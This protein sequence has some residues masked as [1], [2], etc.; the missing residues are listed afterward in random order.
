MKRNDNDV[1]TDEVRLWFMNGEGTM[2][3]RW[4]E[5]MVFE[6]HGLRL[7]YPMHD[8]VHPYQALKRILVGEQ[9]RGEM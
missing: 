4:P 8:E 9:F 7:E 6:E 2:E 3:S 5:S 1:D